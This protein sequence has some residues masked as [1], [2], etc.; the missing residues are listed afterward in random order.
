MQTFFSEM[1][2]SIYD[3]FFKSFYN[4]NIFIRFAQDPKRAWNCVISCNLNGDKAIAHYEPL[5]LLETGLGLC[6][7]KQ[8]F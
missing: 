2:R 1:G 4:L 8:I 7:T 3:H 5:N 6:T